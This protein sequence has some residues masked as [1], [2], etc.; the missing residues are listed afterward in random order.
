[1]KNTHKVSCSSCLTS[2]HPT[3]VILVT[4]NNSLPTHTPS[5]QRFMSLT[6][7]IIGIDKH[8]EQQFSIVV[9]DNGHR[10]IAPLV[11]CRCNRYIAEG[12]SALVVASYIHTSEHFKHKINKDEDDDDVIR[13]SSHSPHIHAGGSSP[14]TGQKER[15]LGKKRGRAGVDERGERA[16]VVQCT[17]C[18]CFCC[19]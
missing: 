15:R 6:T 18:C 10:W 16:G 2:P 4:S 9:A 13:A 11:N 8:V 7:H 19:S 17:R 1:M 14:R 3:T 5:F 12:C